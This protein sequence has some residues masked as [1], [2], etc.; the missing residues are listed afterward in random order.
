MP[1]GSRKPGLGYT[2]HVLHL[3]QAEASCRGWVTGWASK[4]SN[5]PKEKKKKRDQTD[6]G[7]DPLCLA[8]YPR[9]PDCSTLPSKR[10]HLSQLPTLEMLYLLQRFS[11]DKHRRKASGGNRDSIAYENLTS[12]SIHK[13]SRKDDRVRREKAT[14]ICSGMSFQWDVK[15]RH[16]LGLKTDKIAASGDTGT[17][18]RIFLGTYC[19]LMLE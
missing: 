6:N 9:S 5:E 12:N 8:P 17:A 1:V 7:N 3:G 13:Q 2:R 18:R 11:S 19:G 15:S 14:N 16:L 10:S 4:Q